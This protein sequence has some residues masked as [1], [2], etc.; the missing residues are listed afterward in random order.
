MPT[1]I[2]Q[3]LAACLAVL[4]MTPPT[5]AREIAITLDDL[6]YV[7]PSRTSPSEGLTQVRAVTEALAVHGV[8][9]TGFAVG[10]QIG[11]RSRRA[12]SAFAEAGHT[13]GNHSWSHPDYGTLTIDQFREETQRTDET[14]SRWIGESRL[15][16]FPFLREGETEAAKAAADEVLSE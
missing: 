13:V 8:V 12:V 10:G 4:S 16:R 15:Y 6:P 5:A 9:A 11:W 2:T 14:L 7:M 3:A 1:H